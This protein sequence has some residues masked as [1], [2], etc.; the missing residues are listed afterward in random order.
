MRSKITWWSCVLVFAMVYGFVGLAANV[1]LAIDAIFQSHGRLEILHD[2][3]AWTALAAMVML[4]LAFTVGMIAS[5]FTSRTRVAEACID[6]MR[7]HVAALC[8]ACIPFA[9]GGDRPWIYGPLAV[10][11]AVCALFADRK[12]PAHD[13]PW[14]TWALAAMALLVALPILL[15]SRL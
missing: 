14:Q 11:V 7:L 4:G 6:L 13:R 3:G 15:V 10:I 2:G 8:G 9:L 12:G 1:A 5:A